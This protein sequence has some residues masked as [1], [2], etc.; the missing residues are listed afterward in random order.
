[1]HWDNW[2]NISLKQAPETHAL[3][4]PFYPHNY[5]TNLQCH[6]FLNADDEFVIEIS[7]NWLDLRDTNDRLEIDD[8]N[9]TTNFTGS[10]FTPLRIVSA[11][12]HAW[13]RFISDDKDT[14]VG[15]VLIVKQQ[16]RLHSQIG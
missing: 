16:Q 11:T 2:H 6:W 7:V 3:I 13:L 9:V 14:N 12:N 1:M 5:A 15:F 4:S 8:G 10:V